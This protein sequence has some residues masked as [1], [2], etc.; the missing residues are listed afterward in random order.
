MPDQTDL[1]RA[2]RGVAAQAACLVQTINET[3]P[4]F[5]DRFLDRLARVYRE[6]RDNTDGDVTQELELLSWTREYLTGFN[7]VTGQSK[8]LLGE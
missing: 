5:Q 6:F 3:E 1:S 4:E 8:P 7:P 2:K